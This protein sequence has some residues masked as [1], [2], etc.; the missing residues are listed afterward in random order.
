MRDYWYEL[1]GWETP[2]D[3]AMWQEIKNKYEQTREPNN[4]EPTIEGR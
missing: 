1:N 4:I 3:N 2:T